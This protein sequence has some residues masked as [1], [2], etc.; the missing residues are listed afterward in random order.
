MNRSVQE[1]PR[2][3]SLV[4]AAHGSRCGGA[5]R[6]LEEIAAQL[7]QRDGFDQVLTAYNQGEPAFEQVPE[8]VAGDAVVVVPVFLAEGYYSKQVL[9]R[10][11]RR[12]RR[13]GSMDIWL[14]PV[15]GSDSRLHSTLLR[16]LVEL[17]QRL[18]W[19]PERTTVVVLGHGTPRSSSSTLTAR[20]AASFLSCHG[21]CKMVQPA[22]LDDSPSPRAVLEGVDADHC[23]VL[24]FLFGSGGHAAELAGL[25]GLAAGRP[26]GKRNFRNGMLEYFI[27][28][29]VGDDPV[30]VE[31][32]DDLA[33]SR[34][35]WVRL[36]VRGGAGHGS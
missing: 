2:P 14:T 23:I 19:N 33:Q 1:I 20:E 34:H 10:E 30:M 36:E 5:A 7:R 15:V 6:A 29:P 21:P 8:L 11:L 18:G 17:I 35:S 16:R 26:G 4:L 24:P 28:R 27:D 22:F 3:R 31:I 13:S 12:A 32:I 9:P 25:L